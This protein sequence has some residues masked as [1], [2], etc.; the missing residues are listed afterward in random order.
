MDEKL[1]KKLKRMRLQ[2]TPRAFLAEVATGNARNYDIAMLL[3]EAGVPPD[4]REGKA[5][6][7]TALMMAVSRNR[8]L[9]FITR[10]LEAGANPA[11]TDEDGWSSVAHLV[12]A[13]DAE[14]PGRDTF[15]EV[16]RLLTA[17]PDV[18]AE[19]RAL[20]EPGLEPWAAFLRLGQRALAKSKPK[21]AAAMRAP[22]TEAQLAKAE[23]ALGVTI[24]EPL[25]GLYRVFDG[26]A[27]YHFLGK[28]QLYPLAEVVEVAQSLRGRK[29]SN[30]LGARG[31]RNLSWAPSFIPFAQDAAGD[32]LFTT[33]RMLGDRAV[34]KPINPT[35]IYRH[36]EDGVTRGTFRLDSELR[37]LIHQAGLPRK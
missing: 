5:P 24:P 31:H 15:A 9:K 14:I 37:S 8:Q 16:F 30:D 10:L 25:R 18:T 11:L 28:W 36:D 12:C 23:A 7:R 35:Y 3:L 32:V 27:Q 34:I 1:L 20:W 26:M 6:G 22:A 19:D 2:P 21:V 4:S 17:S 29:L 13:F 33:P